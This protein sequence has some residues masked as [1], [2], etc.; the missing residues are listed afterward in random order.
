MHTF[1]IDSTN[2]KLSVKEVSMGFDIQELE[3]SP[4]SRRRAPPVVPRSEPGQIL[5]PPSNELTL[6][7]ES[8]WTRSTSPRRKKEKDVFKFLKENESNYTIRRHQLQMNLILEKNEN[9]KKVG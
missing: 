3:I 5:S 9:V 6:S 7:S 2:S 8:D 1:K 4:N